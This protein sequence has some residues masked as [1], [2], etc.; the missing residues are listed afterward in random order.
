MSTGCW[1]SSSSP[2]YSPVA[3]VAGSAGI[4]FFAAQVKLPSISLLIRL[5]PAAQT[6][7]PPEVT[8]FHGTTLKSCLQPR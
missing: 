8:H 5:G 3:T 7:W 4:P 1:G 6:S 2:E